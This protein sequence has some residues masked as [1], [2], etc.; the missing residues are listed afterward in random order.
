MKNNVIKTIQGAIKGS[1]Q[2][3]TNKKTKGKEPLMFL[4]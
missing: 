1:I 2:F 4:L 3:T